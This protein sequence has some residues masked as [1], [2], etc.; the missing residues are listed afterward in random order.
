MT[1]TRVRGLRGMTLVVCLLV[2]ASACSTMQHPKESGGKTSPALALE[3]VVPASSATVTPGALQAFRERLLS[4]M[5]NS[6][7]D[8][9][10]RDPS[11]AATAEALLL[12]AKVLE[13]PRLG[14]NPGL[15]RVVVAVAFYRNGE[16]VL[17]RSYEEQAYFG[18]NGDG[19]YYSGDQPQFR[20]MNL[21]V[22][23]IARDA[24]KA[25]R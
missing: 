16:L 4:V 24:E 11:G 15:G 7:F 5:K 25:V 13:L 17:D 1:T 6:G 10:L 9:V 14:D 19:N 23:A 18:V 22:R 21:A 12:R 3:I 2:V 20:A 8:P